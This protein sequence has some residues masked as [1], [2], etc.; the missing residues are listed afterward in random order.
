M[1]DIASVLRDR[2]FVQM[3]AG[4]QI[5][6]KS[7]VARGMHLGLAPSRTGTSGRPEMRPRA[8]KTVFGVDRG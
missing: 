7:S 8:V 4:A 5:K 3:A 6:F 2:R 1:Q